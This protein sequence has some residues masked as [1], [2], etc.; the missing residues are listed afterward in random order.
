MIGLKAYISAFGHIVLKNKT[1]SIYHYDLA[2]EQ[3]V[4]GAVQ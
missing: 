1:T 4:S 3:H 2:G